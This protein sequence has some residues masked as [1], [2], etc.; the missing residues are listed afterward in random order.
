MASD[1]RRGLQPQPHAEPRLLAPT[2]AP[3]TRASA[4]R[5]CPAASTTSRCCRATTTPASSP[6]VQAYLASLRGLV[7]A[8]PRWRSPTRSTA[9]AV[10]M[11]NRDWGSRSARRAA[12]RPAS[13]CWSSTTS[14]RWRWRCR[15]LGPA[16]ALQVGGGE[17][18]ANGVIGLIGPGTGLG[19]SGA[20]SQPATLDRARQRGRPRQLRAGRR[21]RARV[22]RHAWQTL[23]HVSNERLISGP[24]LELIHQALA[25]GE[26]PRPACSRRDRAAR[27]GRARCRLRCEAVEC[28]CAMLGTAAAN[29]ASRWAP[30]AASSSAAASCR[31]S[32]SFRP[33]AVPRALRG[34]GPLQRLPAR[35]SRPS[36]SRPR[37]PT[38]L[39]VSTILSAQLRALDEATAAI[40]LLDRVRARARACRRP[41]SASPTSCSSIRARR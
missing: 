28:F 1:L 13:R 10:R 27:A 17:A 30:S 16:T 6:L 34:Q 35:A 36:W 15:A 21:A 33:L 31:A 25:D 20:D 14:P 39:G 2:S 24:G 41:N 29:L 8:T 3:L 9:T 11:T 4:S 19:V 23:P 26:P 32:A 22:L 5:S 40:P 7:R 38:F 37:T 12:L 18:Q